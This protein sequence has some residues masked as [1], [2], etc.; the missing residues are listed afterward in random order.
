MIYLK[1][2]KKVTIMYQYLGNTGIE[3]YGLFNTIAIYVVYIY[4][5]IKLKNKKN[6]LSNISL[7]SIKYFS[8]KNKFKLLASNN[9]WA[10]IETMAIAFVQYEFAGYLGLNNRFGRIFGTGPNYFGLLLFGPIV[11]YLFFYVIAINPLKQM[12]RITPA[13]PLALVFVKL[14]CFFHGCC[15]GIECSWGLYFPSKDAIMFPTQL[16]EAG[17]ALLLY[18]FLILYKKKAKEGT[19]FPIYLTVYSAIRFFTEFSRV[20]EN[21]LWIL[22]K[23]H[24]ICIFGVIVGIAELLIVLK[25]S[26]KIKTIYNRNPF[27]WIREKNII[28]HKTRKKKNRS[29]KQHK[30]QNRSVQKIKTSNMR[31]W[32]IIWTLGLIG[33]IGWNV[34]GT[35]FNTF[36]YEKIDKNP[37]IITPMLICSALATTISIFFFGTLTDR[38]GKRRTLIST[39]FI[40]WGVLLMCFGLTQ[41]MSVNFF[42]LTVICIVLGDMLISFFASM[43][44]DVGYSAWLTDVMND[45]NRG[46]IGGAIAI[47][48]VLGA[49]LGNIIGGFLI[50]KDNYL[51]LFIMIG[52]IL[53]L[54]GVV[55]IFLFSKKDDVE[56]FVQGS[57]LK[58]FSGAF[59]FKNLLKHKELI[60]VNISV[61]VFFMGYN[62]YFPHLGNYIIHY[63]G[64]SPNQLGI[65]EAVP[66]VIAMLVTVPVSKY[67]NNNKFLQVSLLSIISGLI[68]IF[69]VFPVKPDLVDTTKVFDIRLFM[70][71]FLVGVS[72]IIMLQTT[73]AWSKK[74][75]PKESRGQYEGIYAIS[76]ALIPMLFGSNIGEAI[77]KITG[78]NMFNELTG[79]YEY[80]P[81]GN[82]FLIGVIISTLSIIPI[83]ITRKYHSSELKET[84]KSK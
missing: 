55:S 64:F 59:S 74:L 23:Y 16:L 19:L 1:K 73:K 78:E 63:L 10:L 30:V 28:H 38:T 65:I 11:L 70:G 53:S 67:I 35:W 29:G 14:A 37:S 50:G 41:F 42:T 8:D 5:L 26:E 75:H 18:I 58:Q 33:Q 68:G 46:Q 61:A 57:F 71:V 7:F 44:T 31:M 40:I 20:E 60:W 36:V 56:Q 77:V 79:R 24:I 9:L 12:D 82:I 48:S 54:F 27:P 72:Y 21:V 22:K 39:G 17:V 4:N 6:N 69:I 66:L 81:N 13:Y 3:M 15:S 62:T 34:E 45:K 49:L 32:I 25:Y 2:I 76:F 84:E 51:R 47:Q 52:S 43:S 80:I 83:M